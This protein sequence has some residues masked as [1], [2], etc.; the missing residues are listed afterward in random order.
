MNT[1]W[2]PWECQ[3]C[4]T[5]VDADLRDWP[6]LDRE[7]P[8]FA[9]NE[10]RRRRH[11]RVSRTCR[12]DH[13]LSKGGN[14]TQSVSRRDS[15]Q[16]SAGRLRADLETHSVR[17]GRHPIAKGIFDGDRRRE[18]LSRRGVGRV[19]CEGQMVR[20]PSENVE[21]GTCCV[22]QRRG[23]GEQRVARTRRG[24]RQAGKARDPIHGSHC[25]NPVKLSAGWIPVQCESHGAR[26]IRDGIPVSVL[27][28]NLY[29]DR[30]AG[31]DACGLLGKGEP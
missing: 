28:G 21:S 7:L 10:T 18:V 3:D 26:R 13:E 16:N 8:A 11:H 4:S 24:H 22:G 12:L 30:R 25:A 14:A 27:N 19:S 2:A 23:G 9:E 31:D 6:R 15:R 5:G 17:G 1:A 29:A 20:T